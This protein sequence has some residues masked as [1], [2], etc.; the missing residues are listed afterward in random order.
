MKTTRGRLQWV[1]LHLASYHVPHNW[2]SIV[3]PFTGCHQTTGT[4]KAAWREEWQQWFYVFSTSC[5]CLVAKLPRSKDFRAS[6]VSLIRKRWAFHIGTQIYYG[7]NYTVCVHV[8]VCTCVMD[9]PCND[10]CSWSHDFLKFLQKITLSLKWYKTETQLHWKTN[11]KSYRPMLWPMKY[12][13]H[14]YQ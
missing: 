12:E 7:K 8:R 1:Q 3:H 9:F 4:L 2:N 6:I 11:R 13:W 5:N 14:Q 10:V